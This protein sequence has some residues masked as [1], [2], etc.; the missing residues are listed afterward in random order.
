MDG[1]KPRRCNRSPAGFLG[2]VVLVVAAEAAVFGPFDDPS[3]FI[4]ASWRE[5]RRAADRPETLG[6]ALLC[7]GDSQ[8]KCGLLPPV[9]GRQLGLNTVNLA[10]VGG[11]PPSSAY[12]FERALRRGARPRAVVVGYYPALLGAD[13]RINTTK[14]PDLLDPWECLDL[15]RR[16]GDVKLAAPLLARVVFPSLGRRDDVRTAV[17]AALT[18]AADPAVLEARAFRRNW[19]VN[20]GAQALEVNPNFRDGAPPET[21]DL[22]WEC[23]RENLVYV[24]RFLRTAQDRGI[25]V[26]WVMPTNSP[27]LTAARALDGREPAYERFLNGLLAEFPCLTVID[28]RPALTDPATFSDICHLDHR[29]ATQYSL[30]V[31]DAIA[32]RLSGR[33]PRRVV[34]L[35]AGRSAA[36]TAIAVEDVGRSRSLVR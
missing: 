12:L 16:S 20:A 32:G 7:L 24:R 5:S 1:A 22:R 15:L 19:R 23:K 10:V 25:T 27:G 29:G 3:S 4:V 33:D 30:A 17:A 14:W 2:A 21:S 34:A 6:A 26:F 28:P 18:G 11:Q 31:A 35:P 9:V 36:E 8:V 13:L